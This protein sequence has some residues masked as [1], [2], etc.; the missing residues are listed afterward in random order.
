MGAHI[1]VIGVGNPYRGDDGVGPLIA[2]RLREK[3][4]PESVAISE[5]GA[6]AS[7]MDS[8]RGVSMVIIIDAMNSGDL[9]GTTR[10]FDARSESLPR[11][12]FPCSTHYFGVAEAV[13]LARVM[14]RLPPSIIVYGIEGKRF[15]QG[16]GLSPEVMKAAGEIERRVLAD[17]LDEIR[18][19]I[20]SAG[21]G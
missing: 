12:F 13:G 10:R 20:I 7:L 15:E 18:N 19:P 11:A 2:R 5:G 17:I 9:P 3:K 16:I 6:G 8:W 21:S 4:L 14:D 1:L